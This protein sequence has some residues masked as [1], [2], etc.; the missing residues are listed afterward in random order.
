MMK[1]GDIVWSMKTARVLLIG[2]LTAQCAPAPPAR[3]PP[4][5]GIEYVRIEAK[6]PAASRRF[7][8]EELRLPE[9]PCPV[10]DCARYQVGKDQY[11]EVVH[12]THDSDGMQ[13]IAFRTTDAE[14]LRRYL[15]A[16]HVPVPQ[17]VD[18]RADGGAEFAVT[19]AEGHRIA[20]VEP[21]AGADRQGAIS[22]RLIHAGLVVRDTADM[23][24]FY[25][26]V[27]GFRPYW[28]GGMQPGRTDW[29][30]LQ[31]PDGRDWLEY[32]LRVPPDASHHLLGVMNHFSLGVE[33]MDSTE[34]LLRATGWMPHGEEH[35]QMGLD[36]KYQLNVFDPDDVRVEFM[37]FTPSQ[38][39]CCSAFTAP[40]PT[41]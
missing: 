35:K 27:L 22:H 2:L 16:R 21:K 34:A 3:R 23:D 13:V 19:D 15:A 37:S 18:P 24:P 39:P 31:V 5:T 40:H 33:N 11:I 38:P 36:G 26:D 12:A 6:D 41:P 7:Y 32:M 1:N 10:P 4:I 17:S 14:G 9:V 25:Q 8:A 28:H 30:S 20:F 29:I